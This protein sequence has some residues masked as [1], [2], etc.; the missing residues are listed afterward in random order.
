[1]AASSLTPCSVLLPGSADISSHI[2]HFLHVESR[3]RPLAQ[4]VSRKCEMSALSDPPLVNNTME[5]LSQDEAI[6]FVE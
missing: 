4:A 3:F 2:V 5:P 6:P 1:M